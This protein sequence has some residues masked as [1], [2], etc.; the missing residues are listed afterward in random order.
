MSQSYLLNKEIL[1]NIEQYRDKF[2]TLPLL[3]LPTGASVTGTA[4]KGIGEQELVVGEDVF[5]TL[6]FLAE[7]QDCGIDLI[8]LAAY[9]I[10]LQRYSAQEDLFI[11]QIG[12]RNQ[13]EGDYALKCGFHAIRSF[14]SGETTCL[15]VIQQLKATRLDTQYA[16]NLRFDDLQ[17]ILSNFNIDKD[18]FRALFGFDQTGD[19][20]SRSELKALID[21]YFESF[22]LGLFFNESITGISGS[23][24][25]NTA[26]FDPAFI[27]KFIG[28]LSQLLELMAANPNQEIGEYQLLSAEE[29]ERII[30][31]FNNTATP[32]PKEKLLFSLFEERADTHPDA[33][34]LIQGK[35]TLT[36][37][38]LNQQANR[39]AHSLIEKGVL[40]GDNVG[41]LAERDFSMIVGMLGILKAGGAYVP[42]DPD[43]PI[44]RQEYIFNQSVLKLIIADNNY[45]LKSMIDASKFII[46]DF[47]AVDNGKMTNPN[48]KVSS[49]QLAYTIYTSGSTGKPKGVMIEHHSAVNLILWVNK[50]FH[51]DATDRLLFITSMCFDLSVYDIFGILSAG[52]QIVIARQDQIRDVKQLQRMLVDYQITFWDSVPTTLDYLILNLDTEEQG[53]R[54]SGLKTVFLSGDWIPL[55]LPER[56]KKYMTAANVISLGG[57]T[58][59]TVWSNFFPVTA[60]SDQWNSIPY[61][62]PIANNLFYILNKQLQPVPFGVV[63]DLYIGG[64]GV[65]R[66]YAN[67]PDKTAAAFVPDPFNKTLG[68][69]M[70]RTGDLGKMMPD[71]NMEFIGRVD[72]QV[73]IQGFR[74]ELGEIENVLKGCHLI[75]NAVVLA[76]DDQQ[77]KKRLIAYVMPEGGKFNKEAVMDY[78]RVKLPGYMIPSVWVEMEILPLTSNGKIDRKS[79]PDV[80]PQDVVTAEAR[81]ATETELIL[82]SIWQECMGIARI[83][84]NANFFELGGHSLKAV[85]ILSKF[86]K[87]T[88]KGFQISVLFKHP[89]IESLARFIDDDD[90]D[91]V[92]TSLIPIKPSGSKA[93][94]YIIHGEG[95]NVL[96]FSE[97]A[98]CIDKDQPI[99]GLQAK[100]LNGID[101]PFDSIPDIAAHY[102]EEILRHNPDGPYI[103][104][105]YSFGGY[106]AVEMNRQLSVLGKKVSMLIMFDT[107]AEKTEYKDW[108]KLFPKKVKR[109]IPKLLTFIRNSVTQPVNTF[110]NQSQQAA[111]KRLAKESEKFYQQIGIIKEKHLAAFRKYQLK[112]FDNKVYLF[113]A[114]IC[115]HYVNDEQYLGWK[116][117]ARN[118]V[119]VLQVPGDHLSMLENPN[120]SILA[121]ILE[122]TLTQYSQT[123]PDLH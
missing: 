27:S 7:E 93:P 8:L 64:V 101:E 118:G 30:V 25:Y 39:L 87:R 6:T 9:K 115:V 10:L 65:A 47:N 109:N 80:H 49:Q 120:V 23:L 85:Q 22:Y 81:P 5:K 92:F 114:D 29:W 97:L 103:L 32:Y 4:Q 44:E 100:G 51:V 79:L 16:N 67:D 38:Q 63:G 68:G 28:H 56:I 36:Y 69:M 105:G 66:G 26:Y 75:C 98:N 54:Y 33:I 43:Y 1:V 17:L 119:E 2:E 74:I 40:P 102:L 110:K 104:A 107:N 94:L 53:Y 111:K 76:K 46:I 121:D 21:I 90:Q 96:N 123:N 58:E 14:I 62:K 95:L 78:L 37:Q 91:I 24:C 59:G 60:T 35:R 89:D 106:V 55:S 52:G 13:H 122:R 86:E 112:P 41:I 61:G 3:K 50:T 57:A 108:Y 83:A 18:V 42:V 116:K 11:T 117:Y 71:L 73:K 48:V 12:L 34:A 113:R 31:E 84:L 15:E 82:Q 20:T 99:Y 72:N 70:Y 77:G 45:P 19:V 88:G